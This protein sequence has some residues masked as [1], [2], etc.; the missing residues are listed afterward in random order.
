MFQPTTLAPLPA[1][2]GPSLEFRADLF[3]V[4]AFQPLDG[5][6][7]AVERSIGFAS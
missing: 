5:H 6:P 1:A 7:V 3:H 4:T 2:G